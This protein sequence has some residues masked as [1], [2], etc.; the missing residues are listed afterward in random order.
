MKTKFPISFR[1]DTWL[2]SEQCDWCAKNST[3]PE[4]VSL[5]IGANQDY[6]KDEVVDLS[7]TEATMALGWHNEADNEGTGFEVLADTVE[8]Q[9]CL[10]FCSPACLRKFLN[11]CVD[12]LE[13][14]IEKI[15]S[16]QGNGEGR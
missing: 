8:G 7:D 16:E 11:S 10:N 6:G 14:R 5:A 15:K 3:S 1:G 4:F 12:H 9:A 13:S 2:H